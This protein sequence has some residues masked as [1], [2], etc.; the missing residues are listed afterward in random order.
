L[1][2]LLMVL[3]IAGSAEQR[4]L[5]SVLFVLSVV[6]YRVQA[7]EKEGR[8]GWR[9]CLQ[10]LA[11]SPAAGMGTVADDALAAANGGDGDDGERKGWDPAKLLRSVLQ[12]VGDV[13]K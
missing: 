5:S 6:R 10:Q 7:G 11:A 13:R 3:E 8:C 4:M 9:W 12:H 2:L 1:H